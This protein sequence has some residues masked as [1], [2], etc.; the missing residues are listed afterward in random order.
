VPLRN[1]EDIAQNGPIVPQ[2]PAAASDSAASWAAGASSEPAATRPAAPAKA[3]IAT[4]HRLALVLG[5][6]RPI[7]TR[8]N[9]AAIH[10][11]ALTN[12]TATSL[13]PEKNRMIW[14]SHRLMP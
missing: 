5:E 7:M 3:D 9:D 2:M 12:P 13:R 1:S 14:G 11:I 4:C 10:G 6:L 8:P